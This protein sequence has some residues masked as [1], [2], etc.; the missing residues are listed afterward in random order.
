V[1][2]PSNDFATTELTATVEKPYMVNFEWKIDRRKNNPDGTDISLENRSITCKLSDLD[3]RWRIH[4]DRAE[5]CSI[6]V[7]SYVYPDE[8]EEGQI[9]VKRMAEMVKYSQKRPV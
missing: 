5:L 4:P 9:T 2:R 7:I 6:P 8:V 3:R 1:L